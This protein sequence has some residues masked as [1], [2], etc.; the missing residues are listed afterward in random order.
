MAKVNGK[1]YI[2]SFLGI[3]FSILF[4][5]SGLRA[6]S[7]YVSL[8]L[9]VL[10]IIHGSKDAIKANGIFQPIV[11][12]NIFAAGFFVLRPIQL[13]ITQNLSEFSYFKYY[14]M[15]YGNRIISELPFSEAS[16]IG[17]IGIWVTNVCYYYIAGR[18]RGCTQKQ[19]KQVLEYR[20]RVNEMC[21]A[22]I[23]VASLI[24]LLF[25]Y[26][27]IILHGTATI[28]HILWVYILTVVLS[29]HILNNGK[30]T[31]LSVICFVI[32][33]VSLAFLGNRQIIISLLLCVFATYVTIKENTN[34]KMQK[35]LK[36]VAVV[37]I[38]AAVLVAWY[39]SFKQEADLEIG[40]VADEVIGEFGMYDMLV[41]SLDHKIRCSDPFL[42]G[43][44]YLC[45]F[46]WLIPGVDIDFFDFRLVQIVYEGFLGGGIPISI[47]GSFYYNFGYI[48]LVIGSA[49][50]GLLMASVYFRNL[51]KSTAEAFLHNIIFL[52]FIYDVT[53]VGD[54]GRELINYF[55]LWGI[56][57][58]AMA[59]VPKRFAYVD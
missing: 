7:L 20:Q 23:A 21:Y 11:I 25:L 24:W 10:L 42:Y 33:C 57:K 56:L 4:H 55:V 18:N 26:N 15:L 50:F 53:R 41:L 27:A 17:V 29:V 49:L 34:V 22:Y 47:F 30:L 48:G 45:L 28:I 52:T 51:K 58:I 54:I 6:V 40:G 37:G 12:C 59:F 44:N 13:L 5:L 9:S 39:A 38:A 35:I 46:N 32:S 2:V 1:T 8:A 43:Y 3:L 14:F 36:I 19:F 31:K 16:L